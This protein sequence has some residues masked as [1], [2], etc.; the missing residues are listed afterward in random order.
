MK[1][2]V[3]AIGAAALAVTGGGAAVAATSLVD[4]E[5]ESEAVI[6]DA[7]SQLGVQPSE[8]TDALEQALLKR[9]DA[10]LA[11]GRITQAQANEL[12]QRIQS[13]DYPLIGPVLG[14]R[15]GPGHGFGHVE[16]AATYLGLTEAELRSQLEGGKTM[17]DVAKAQGKTVDGLVAALVADEKKELDAAVAAGRLT[18][19]Q[20]NAM[21]ADAKSRF[22]DMVN[23]TFPDHGPRGF[24]GTPPAD[25]AS[26]P[27][28]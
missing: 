9:V 1:R 18:Q 8:L 22:T 23:G 26:T 15:G 4:P 14:H 20:A 12:R 24:R 27:D 10:A 16:A 21:L 19:A 11:A 5:Q 3:V 17:A 7:A 28:A 13:G 25:D 6:D 2:K